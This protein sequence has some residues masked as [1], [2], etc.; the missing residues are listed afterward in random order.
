M[1]KKIE[2]YWSYQRIMP[3]PNVLYI[4]GFCGNAPV[5]VIL[6]FNTDSYSPSQ[7]N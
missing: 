7:M 6:D 3:P 1:T 2:I 5:I 4:K